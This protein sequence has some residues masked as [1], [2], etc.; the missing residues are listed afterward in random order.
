MVFCAIL[1]DTDHHRSSAIALRTPFGWRPSKRSTPVKK[2]LS[3]TS[4]RVEELV[5]E[6]RQLN[7]KIICFVT[8]VPGA[9]KTLV[10]LNV[11]TRHRKKG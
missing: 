3:V 4:K 2:N 11:A 10:G 7:Q 5:N 9:G 8:G 6:A 1:P